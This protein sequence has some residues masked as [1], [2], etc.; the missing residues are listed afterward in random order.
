MR[1]NRLFIGCHEVAGYYRNLTLG[2][3]A[4]GQECDYVTFREHP[5]QY[6]GET[7]DHLIPKL[8]KSINKAIGS[9][10]A[11]IWLL[12]ALLFALNQIIGCVYLCVCLIRYDVFIFGFGMSLLHWNTDIPILKLCGKKIIMNMAHGSESRPPYID[13]AYQ[14]PDGKA[15][16]TAREMWS[17]TRSH[18]TRMAFLEDY[19]D[20]I[21]GAPFSSTHFSRKKSINTFSIGIPYLST[22]SVVGDINDSHTLTPEYNKFT[23]TRILHSPSHPA[24]KGSNAIRSCIERLRLKGYQV[25]FIELRGRPNREVVYEIRQCDFVIDQVYCDTPMAGFATEAAW[26][27]K[28]AVVGGYSFEYLQQF[29]HQDMFPP[30]RTCHPD[31]LELAIEELIVNPQLRMALGKK[32][33]TFVQTQWSSEKVAERYLRLITGDIPNSWWL[34][35]E[36]IT[37]LHGWGQ[38]EEQTK[39]N[40]RKMV[41][42]YGV[43]SL[44][45]SHRP[46]LENAFLEFAGIAMRKLI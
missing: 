46:E 33:Q 45:L 35:P 10:F 9:K 20:C 43:K 30:S 40:I 24:G 22:R 18:A 17:L 2:L 42:A 44:Q 3:R 34:D 41:K 23:K 21:I 27:A 26:F 8:I 7:H 25:E 14:S 31:E 32:A 16:P 4:L 15:K 29:I 38:T 13:G 36:Q 28:P 6:G 11:K 1:S 19:A 12:R 5:F 39:E 37:Y